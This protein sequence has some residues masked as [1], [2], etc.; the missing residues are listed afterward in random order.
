M[1]NLLLQEWKTLFEIAPFDKISDDDF[2]PAFDHAL[3][4]DMRETIAVSYTHLTL[5]TILRV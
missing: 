2:S 5:P 1:N 3:S 4:A